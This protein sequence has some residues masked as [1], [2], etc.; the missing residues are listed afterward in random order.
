MA[1][2]N[3]PAI[4]N[5]VEYIQHHL[6]N[7]TLSGERPASLVDFSVFFV[8]LFVG[9]LARLVYLRQCLLYLLYLLYLAV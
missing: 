1:E 2:S 9:Q 7:M 3:A 8:D 6:G 4:S 5:P